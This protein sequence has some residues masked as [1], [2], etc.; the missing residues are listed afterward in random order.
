[1]PVKTDEDP[2]TDGVV[3]DSA[4]LVDDEADPI[5]TT[6]SVEDH[7]EEPEVLPDSESLVAAGAAGKPRW[8]RRLLTGVL[9]AVF[10]GAVGAAGFLG[11]QQWQDR[12]V[13]RASAEAESAAVSYA[14]VL[15]SIDSNKV[16]ENFKQVLDGATGQ[17][18]DMYTQASTQL[19]Q[20]LIE[21]KA[22]AKGVVVEAGVKSASKDEV[23]VLMFVD[24]S[25]TNANVPDPRI[26]RS[27]V[28]MTMK[29]VDGTW[30]ASQVEII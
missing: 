11:W 28:K 15:T 30:R 9:A 13:A 20:L 7:G 24:Q 23:V 3:Q 18:K 16:D 25:V 19:R 2:E 8:R 4:E 27:R 5:Q 14:Q 6:E 17:F 21:N 29:K 10:V 22:A 1:M 26:D 12:Q